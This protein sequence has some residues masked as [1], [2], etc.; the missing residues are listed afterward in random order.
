MLIFYDYVL[1]Q[2]L[3]MSIK[4]IR[5]YLSKFSTHKSV[6]LQRNSVF[7]SLKCIIHVTCYMLQKKFLWHS[8]ILVPSLCTVLREQ[9]LS[10][11]YQQQHDSFP[12]L[13]HLKTFFC[14]ADAPKIKDFG[15]IHN[16]H[17]HSKKNGQHC[18]LPLC[19]QKP[20]S[21]DMF[22]HFQEHQKIYLLAFL[23]CGPL[24]FSQK[25]PGNSTAYT[26][27][28]QDIFL[29]PNRHDYI[30]IITFSALS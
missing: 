20:L 24:Q 27:Q 17:F 23:A 11:C 2:P 28:S 22:Y 30:D 6:M 19:T 3:H 10:L 15:H 7:L 12:V 8:Q 13:M 4:K 26:K 21:H 5:L 14:I 9:L 25:L 18:I 1:P 16:P 29:L